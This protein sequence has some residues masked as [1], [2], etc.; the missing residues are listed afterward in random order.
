[1]AAPA[2]AGAATKTVQ[3]GPF[4][5]GRQFQQAVGDANEYFRRT[6]T[7]RRG[8]RVRW[9][10]NG[11]HSVTF[12]PPG[13]PPPPLAVPDPATPIAGVNDAAGNPFWFNDQPTLRPNPDAI[14]P[15]GDGS[16]SRSDLHNSGL[17]LAQG[18]PEPYTLRFNRKGTFNYLCVVHPGMA[19][20]VRVVGRG[21]NVP[22]ARKD[23][24]EA[25]RQLNVTLQ[26]VQRLSNGLGTEDLQ[27]T[28]QAG[29][30]RR[31][32]AT[33][34]KFFPNAPSFG[35]GD[36][37]RMA[38]RTTEL[39]TFTFGPADYNEEI[40]NVL[41]GDVFEPRGAYPSEPPAAGVPSITPG[42]HGNGFYNSGFLDRDGASPLPAST[43]VTFG[44][45]GE[46]SL[47]C[48]I[49]PFMAARVTVTP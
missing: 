21:A 2:A 41:L 22:S 9:R 25:R 45:P 28:I 38:P 13:G 30:D 37:V 34:F 29:N 46:Y 11:F 42:N 1:L 23:R 16:F 39:H 36:T 27:N 6:I 24:R 3:A 4:A 35:V 32:G 10:I 31:S 33:V 8:D 17:P 15:Q 49:H 19:G 43:T 47:I 26:R 20:K 44:A 14:L 18:P 5:K 12:A 40:A 7:I 48:L